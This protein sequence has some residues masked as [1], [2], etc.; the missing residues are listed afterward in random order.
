MKDKGYLLAITSEGGAPA[1]VARDVLRES[2][3]G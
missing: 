3:K 1:N 2:E